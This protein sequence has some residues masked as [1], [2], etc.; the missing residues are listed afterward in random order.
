[1]KEH[2]NLYGNG[3]LNMG[4]VF[5]VFVTGFS[6]YSLSVINKVTNRVVT[7]IKLICPH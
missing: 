5:W 6:I 2:Q 3:Y 1:M 4:I 7:H